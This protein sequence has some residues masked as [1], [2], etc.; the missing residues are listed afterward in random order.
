MSRRFHCQGKVRR[1][2]EEYACS[3][4]AAYAVVD[5]RQPP[6]DEVVVATCRHHVAQV[7]DGL[8]GKRL[9]V[10]VLL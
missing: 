1:Y 2:G 7:I 9:T 10:V 5:K 3:S 8:N 4:P 6:E